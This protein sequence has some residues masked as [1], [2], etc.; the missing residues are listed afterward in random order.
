MFPLDERPYLHNS[1]NEELE[2]WAKLES[3]SESTEHDLLQSHQTREYVSWKSVCMFVL[4]IAH[5]IFTKVFER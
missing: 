1:R 4:H 2:A 5:A 3:K